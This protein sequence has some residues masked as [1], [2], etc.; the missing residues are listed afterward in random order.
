MKRKFFLL[1]FALLAFANSSI[2]QNTGLF[3]Y[4]GGYFIKNGNNWYEY[5]PGD[6]AGVWASYTQYGEEENFYNIKNKN[7]FVSVPKSPSNSFFVAPEGG[8]W[9][10]I[11]TTRNFYSVFTDEGRD[12]YCYDGGYFVRNGSTWREYRPEDKQTVWSTYSLYKSDDNFFYIESSVDKVAIPKSKDL[13]GSIFVYRNDD[14]EAIYTVSDIYESKGNGY[15][16]GVGSSSG[17]NSHNSGNN[18]NYGN[19]SSQRS[20]DYT[21]RFSCYEI[22]DDKEESYGD[23]IYAPCS[24]SISRKGYGLISYGSKKAEFRFKSCIEYEGRKDVYNDGLG[25][26]GMLF[27]GITYD[28]RG[29]T[30]Y[31][32]IDGK[33]EIVTYIDKDIENFDSTE[34]DESVL[35]VEGLEGVPDMKFTKCCNRK[36]GKEIHDIIVNHKFFN[37]N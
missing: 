37:K 15:Y 36:T 31:E 17:N 8:E 13:S 16:A 30:L 20:Y 2:A 1:F 10:S 3:T 19:N 22:W 33:N 27:V 32:D 12:L 14:W 6:K 5:R 7:N 18:G 11:Y 26:L 28:E 29:F 4:A 24:V 21:L 25:I 34:G 23:D 35:F 9:K